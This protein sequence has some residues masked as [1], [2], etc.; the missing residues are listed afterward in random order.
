[1]IRKGTIFRFIK[2][3]NLEN[4]DQ[5]VFDKDKFS[6]F[7]LCQEIGN[8]LKLNFNNELLQLDFEI[9]NKLR[10]IISQ[11]VLVKP[12]DRL[13][14]K[15]ASKKLEQLDD[16]ISKNQIK[17]FLLLESFFLKD[18]PHMQNIQHSSQTLTIS[19][20]ADEF[21]TLDE[22][23]DGQLSNYN[24]PD[25]AKL[26]TTDPEQE[27]RITQKN[28]K[29]C[30]SISAMRLLSF[31]FITFLQNNLNR[32]TLEDLR[33][34]IF[35]FPKNRNFNKKANKQDVS[36][37]DLNK[38]PNESFIQKLVTICCGV[39]SPRSLNG[40]NNLELKEPDI[41][42]QEQ[43]ISKLI[44]IESNLACKRFLRR[45]FGASLRQN[46]I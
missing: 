9:F 44:Q 25:D 10:C 16:F 17:D 20:D 18:D 31:A 30:V 8:S 23:P 27:E 29:L 36:D 6:M 42:A 19:I 33:K 14:L 21:F 35:N 13:K 5:F 32:R 26:F 22:N 7:K 46:R 4:N 12:E 15:D 38:T 24:S 39:I 40:L 28:T 34:I 37:D 3:A 1:M 2:N 43:N 11:L 41:S 45:S